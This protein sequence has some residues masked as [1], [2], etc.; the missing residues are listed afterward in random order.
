MIKK[1]SEWLSANKHA[2]AMLY[3]VFYLVAFFTLEHL[4]RP[5]YIIH[6]FLDDYISF[7]EYF[8]IP[9]FLWF[10]CLGLS[11]IGFMIYEKETFLNLCLMM[12][13]GMTFCLIT[14][15]IIPNGL[16]LRGGI[17]GNNIFCQITRW[18][19]AFDTPTN[20]CPSIHV[21]SSVS[22]TFAVWK[23]KKLSAYPK[24]QFGGIALMILICV[25]TVFLNQHSV[26]DV[27]CGV[28]LTT[29]L[30]YLAYYTNW[31]SIPGRIANE[32]SK[33]RPEISG[34]QVSD[35]KN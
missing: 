28:L 34:D 18:L 33:A 3:F 19:Y 1:A 9:Y 23:S 17:E 29:V 15:A 11:L 35:I 6:S 26:I 4:K 30:F 14:Y 12:F 5:Q 13:G 10:V 32:I 24:F 27:F 2:Y 8:V 21:A 20:V 7:N 22:I 31:M 16:N 25:S